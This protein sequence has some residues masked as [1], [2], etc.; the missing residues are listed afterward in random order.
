MSLRFWFW[1]WRSK[2]VIREQLK[3]RDVQLEQA[4]FRGEYWQKEWLK[5]HRE[6]VLAHAALRRK[7]KALKILHK[8]LQANKEGK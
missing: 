7:G 3:S 2:Q 4:R 6:L 1:N 5:L 8:R